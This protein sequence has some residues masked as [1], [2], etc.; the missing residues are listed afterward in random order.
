[1][2]I[3]VLMAVY[4]SEKPKYLDLSLKSI[5]E[6]QTLKPDEIILVEDGPLGKDLLE[7]IRQHKS[8]LGDK[9]KILKN[10]YN[11]GLTKSLNKGLKI[12]KGKYIARM[13]SDDISLPSRFELQ[14]SFMESNPDVAVLGGG[15]LEINENEDIGAERRYP[16]DQEKIRKYIVKANPLA[17]PTTFIR[18]TVFDNGFR[19]DE[20]YRKNQDL[21][22]WFD[23]L[24]KDYVLHNLPNIVLKFRRT[25]K[26]YE[27]RSNKNALKSEREIYDN[28]ICAL[29]G[30]T[31]LKRFFPYIRFLIKSMPP[32]VNKFVYT[33]L[34]KKNSQ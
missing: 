5:Y 16:E 28:G 29:Y 9:L 34:F 30:K 20:R 25:Q 17:H 7:V 14:L 26:T 19:Y 33:Y 31:S 2:L 21:K 10:E 6:D 11:L 1:M 22:L 3:S 13:D 12:A 4:K 27:K 23:L 15:M 8:K 18:R 32:S 24:Q